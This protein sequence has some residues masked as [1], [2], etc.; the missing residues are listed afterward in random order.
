MLLSAGA[1]WWLFSGMK[2]ELAPMEDQGTVRVTANAPDGATLDYTERYMREIERIGMDYP[3]FDRTFILNGYP[4]VSQGIASMRTVDWAERDRSSQQLARLMQPRLAALP[5][6]SAFPV[7]PPSLG[8][9][10]RE[11]A[12]NFVIV[13]SDAIDPL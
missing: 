4:T 1:S 5:G 7:T 13:T 9:G 2:S 11:R 12:I 3:E 8:G 10:S 6:V